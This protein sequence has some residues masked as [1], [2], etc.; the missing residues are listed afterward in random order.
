MSVANS[1]SLLPFSNRP[2]QSIKLKGGMKNSRF[3][4][5]DLM[6]PAGPPLLTL[7]TF[8][9]R[10]FL[11]RL[12]QTG[13]IN[14]IETANQ[15]LKRLGVIGRRLAGIYNKR[16]RT[17]ELAIHPMYLRSNKYN[18]WRLSQIGLGELI[19]LIRETMCGVYNPILSPKQFTRRRGFGQWW[20]ILKTKEEG[21][22]KGINWCWSSPYY[23]VHELSIT[24]VPIRAVW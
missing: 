14:R 1:L 24:R 19:L 16:A 4:K 21:K 5:K 22:K 23:T 20:E 3:L 12:C 7:I 10:T 2:K 13:W 8:I 6:G 15:R 17:K 18:C 9:R 11:E